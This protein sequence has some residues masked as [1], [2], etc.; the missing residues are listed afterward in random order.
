M[1]DRRF[2]AAIEDATAVLA[3]LPE[4]PDGYYIRCLCYLQSGQIKEGREDF[5]KAA[6]FGLDDAAKKMI[7]D[8]LDRLP[9]P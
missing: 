2:P 7:Q 5:E 4:R 9:A 3:A 1:N 8:F 6:R